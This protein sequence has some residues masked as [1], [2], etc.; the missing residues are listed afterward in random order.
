MTEQSVEPDNPAAYALARHIADHPV[1]TI[2]AAFRYLNAPL[3]I[4]F[5][6]DPD[7]PSVPPPPPATRAALRDRIA[8]AIG[9]FMGAICSSDYEAADAVLAVLPPPADRAAVLAEAITRVEDPAERAKTTTGAGLG[10]E[11]A[12]DVLRRMADEEQQQPVVPARPTT[13]ADVLCD[14]ADCAYRIARRL[15]DQHH[16]QRAQGAWDVENVLRAQ[17]RLAVAD[18]S[19]MA[20][21]AQPAT[22]ARGSWGTRP[23]CT[24][25]HAEDEHSVYGCLDDCA[26][27][28]MPKRK[29]MDP[30]HILGI[31][32]DV[33]APVAQQPAAEVPATLS[34]RHAPG[35][36]ILCPDCRA[37]GYSV[38]MVDERQPAAA[39]TAEE[40]QP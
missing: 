7:V 4:E 5:H 36:A 27:E 24:C 30:V 18:G 26:C 28:W 10:W 37:K 19:R 6:E 16:D 1:S 20:D 3:T 22:E 14:A 40:Q 17:A 33:P 34:V 13:R 29:P 15:D 2:Q 21:E 12:R 23:R 8:E 39:D 11:A 25:S 9:D 38:C 32:A 31:D 35:I